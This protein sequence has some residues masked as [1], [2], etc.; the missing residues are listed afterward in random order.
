MAPVLIDRA[1]GGSAQTAIDRPRASSRV[2]RSKFKSK[3]HCPAF[4]G[5]AFLLTFIARLRGRSHYYPSVSYSL[6]RIVNLGGRIA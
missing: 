6:A 4:N 1:A 2:A 5:G 3:A